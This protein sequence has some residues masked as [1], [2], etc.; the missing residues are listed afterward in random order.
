MTAFISISSYKYCYQHENPSEYYKNQAETVIALAKQATEDFEFEGILSL[1]SNIGAGSPG[2]L[3]HDAHEHRDYALMT[4]SNLFTLNNKLD[5]ATR[6][7]LKINNLENVYKT[8]M[9]T[10]NMNRNN[11]DNL[12]KIGETIFEATHINGAPVQNENYKIELAKVI[13]HINVLIAKIHL[14]SGSCLTDKTR[15]KD[16]K[17]I[18][19]ESEKENIIPQGYFSKF[20]IQ[21]QP[22]WIRITFN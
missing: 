2:H 17:D 8:L 18:Y 22:G 11:R 6:T 12:V 9:Y 3:S 5:L 21:K 13:S 7:A 10:A 1:A 15:E 19:S 14:S 20:T 16:P 4:L